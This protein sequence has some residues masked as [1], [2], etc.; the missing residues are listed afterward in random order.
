[1][2]FHPYAGAA[3]GADFRNFWRVG[4]HRQRNHR[5]QIS[6]RSVKGFRVYGYPKSGVSHWLWSSP[7]QQ[8]YALSCYTVIRLTSS[9]VIITVRPTVSLLLTHDYRWDNRLLDQAGEGRRRDHEQNRSSGK[10]HRQRRH[11]KHQQQ[12]QQQQQSPVTSPASDVPPAL[13]DDD[14]RN[15][16][17]RRASVDIPVVTLPSSENVIDINTR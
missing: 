2:I 7:L 5:R 13:V 12:Q 9:K 17:P 16:E 14:N 10:H 3:C 6:S 8:C 11:R 1:M 15:A 4:S